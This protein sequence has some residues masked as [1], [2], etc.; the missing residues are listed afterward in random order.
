M[1]CSRARTCAVRLRR[2][3]R[4]ARPRCSCPV[5]PPF[6]AF[7]ASR[8]CR[9]AVLV[10]AGAGAEEDAGAAVADR[11]R[12]IGQD[13]RAADRIAHHLD[14]PRRHPAA[15]APGPAAHAL[16]DAINEAPEGARDDD[17]EDDEERKAQHHQAPGFLVTPA[18]AD[19]RLSIARFAACPS[20]PSGAS[21]TTWRHADSAPSRSCLPNAFTMPTLSS[22]LACLGS[23]LSDWSNCASALSGWFE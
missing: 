5:R 3:R 19:V 14:A 6:E 9:A 8:A 12:V 2:C 22:V 21:A 16:D 4:G 23:S 7:T 15:A 11:E 10:A 17:A 13:E 20:G 1:P 18:C